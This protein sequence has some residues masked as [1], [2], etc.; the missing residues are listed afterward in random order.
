MQKMRHAS[1]DSELF[2]LSPQDLAV[3]MA[4]DPAYLKQT[5]S[6]IDAK[7]GSFANY[8]RQALHVSDADVETLKR[9]LL[10]DN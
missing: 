9:K 5:L 2:R 1:G 6:D 8:R 3:L 4:A 7:Y 10:T